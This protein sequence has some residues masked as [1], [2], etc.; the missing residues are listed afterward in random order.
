M[1]SPG[2]GAWTQSRFVP[3]ELTVSSTGALAGL[4]PRLTP[5]PCD[6][7]NQAQDTPASPSPYGDLLC[8]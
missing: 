5:S 6:H 1:Q 7:H 4:V 2:A 8:L 3:A